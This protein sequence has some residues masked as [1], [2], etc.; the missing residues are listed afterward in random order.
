MILTVIGNIIDMLLKR[1]ETTT[2]EDIKALLR[3]A[4]IQISDSEL[5]K[6]L[7]TLEIHKKI[8]VKK[9]KKEGREIFQISRRK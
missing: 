5:V 9:I 1:Q 4:N 3:R 7:M 2:S 8:Y 6:V